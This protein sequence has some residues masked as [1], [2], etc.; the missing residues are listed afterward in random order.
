MAFIIDAFDR[1]I[2]AWTAVCGVGI[3]GSRTSSPAFL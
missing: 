1:E 2:L 3:S